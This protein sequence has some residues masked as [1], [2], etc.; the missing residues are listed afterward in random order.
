M[1]R[2]PLLIGL[3]ALAHAAG[4][5]VALRVLGVV[6]AVTSVLLASRIGRLVAQEAGARWCAVAGAAFVSMPLFDARE[7]DGELLALPFVLGSIALVLSGSRRSGA[8]RTTG[9]LLAAGAAAAAAALVKQNLVDGAV[10]G[11]AYVVT[12]AVRGHD[13]Q[14]LVRGLGALAAGAVATGAVVMAAAAARGTGPG[15][16][17]DALV[18][19]RGQAAAQ[20]A[21]DAGGSPSR[22]ARLPVALATSGGL[23]LLGLA[24]HRLRRTLLRSP[25]GVATL[26]LTGWELVGILA[27]GSYWLHY[28]LGLVPALVLAAALAIHERDRWA[29]AARLT[30]LWAA[31][32]AVVGMVA[33]AIAHPLSPSQRAGLW[34]RAHARPSD[35]AVVAFGGANV[36]TIAG[37]QSPYDQLWSLPVRVRDPRLRDLTATLSGS[38]APT[39]VLTQDRLGGWQLEPTAAR[40]VLDR[41]Y[42]QVAE[43]AGYEVYRLRARGRGSPPP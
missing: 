21:G 35:T 11:A 42:R 9:L 26:A 32:V 22:L 34:L 14:R 40:T 30:L 20:L 8:P 43:V 31:G 37:L 29:G 23:L 1:D 6:A 7:V 36:V 38:R 33:L 2:P 5:L 16:L 15:A 24:A 3:Y 4:G 39:W 12:D 18:V 10:F 28:L 41:R 17:W 19:F 27:G 13:R 25:L